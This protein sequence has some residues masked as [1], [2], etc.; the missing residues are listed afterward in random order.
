[1][2]KEQYT[3]HKNKKVK[4]SDDN[5]FNTIAEN[6]NFDLEFNSHNHISPIYDCRELFPDLHLVSDEAFGR[7]TIERC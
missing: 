6:S 5:D 1:M 4:T 7:S 3:T 2:P